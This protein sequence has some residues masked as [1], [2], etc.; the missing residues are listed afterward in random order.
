[1]DHPLDIHRYQGIEHYRQAKR[2]AFERN[3][4]TALLVVMPELTM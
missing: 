4:G 2:F 1:M 3:T